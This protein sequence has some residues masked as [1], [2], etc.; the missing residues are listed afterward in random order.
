[1][2]DDADGIAR[3]YTESAEHHASIDPARYGVSAEDETARRY[4]DGRQHHA[5]VVAIT[6]VAERNGEA[7]GF[8]DARLDRSPDPMH[9]NLLYCVIVEIAVSRVHQ[10]QGIGGRLLH[11]AEV[12]GR[13]QGADLA[14]LEYREGNTR[15]ASFYHDRM[16]YRPAHITAIK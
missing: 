10:S 12:W 11:A 1:V 16:G 4:R 13:E 14:S 15:V 8:I 5:Q 9:K 7:L 6:L 3:I 2:S